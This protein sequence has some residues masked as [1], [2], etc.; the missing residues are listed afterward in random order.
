[1]RRFLPSLPPP[2]PADEWAAD[3]VSVE[4]GAQVAQGSK[5]TATFIGADS[6][7]SIIYGSNSTQLVE[8]LARSFEST[9][10]DGD[11]IVV[12]EEHET[13][14]G[15]WAKM[16]ARLAEKG[17][18]VGLKYWRHDGTVEEENV[19]LSL[20]TLGTLVGEK[21]KLVAFSACSNLLGE[22]TDIEGAV[23]LI[24]A[25]SGGKARTCLDCVAFSPHRRMKASEWGVDFLFFSY[26]KVSTVSFSLAL[27]DTSAGVRTPLFDPLRPPRCHRHPVVPR[28]LLP[29]PRSDGSLQTLSRRL[30]LRA[31]FGQCPR[32]RLPLFALDH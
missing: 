28:T 3:K 18:K 12:A 27:A 1:M 20:E 19:R 6:P 24:K 8:N 10:V 25:K 23:K 29:H 16:V 26:Y 13:N 4:S 15:P 31:H 11:E 32:L 22:L 9:L 30:S 2:R 17:I 7:K 21:T 5:T 14:V